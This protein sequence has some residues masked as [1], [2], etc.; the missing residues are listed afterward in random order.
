MGT[1]AS[2][3]ATAFAGLS[4]RRRIYDWIGWTACTL[5]F[6]L[7]AAAMA[8]ILAGVAERGMAAMHWS[9]LTEIT[10]GTGGGLRNAIEGT[11]VL[12]LGGLALAVP[13]GVA[14]G[15]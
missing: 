3:A 12:A 4:L 1:T 14:C 11:L 10:Q 2:N 9:L 13:P 5:A 6:L 7:L 8:S 15:V